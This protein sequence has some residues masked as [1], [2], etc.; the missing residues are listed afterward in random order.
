MTVIIV[1]KTPSSGLQFILAFF[2]NSL[3]ILLVYNFLLQF[4]DKHQ[5]K[6]PPH[7]PIH[8]QLICSHFA[9]DPKL[10]SQH[11]RFCLHK[12]IQNYSL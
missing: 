4:Y 2:A 9:F 11:Y 5:L 1:V 3:A 12:V 6:F 10:L 7:Y 8:K